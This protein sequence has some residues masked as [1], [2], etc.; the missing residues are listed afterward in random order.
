MN[1]NVVKLI[2][3]GVAGAFVGFFLLGVLRA[4]GLGI[5][6]DLLM[7]ACFGVVIF[8]VVKNL[9]TNR[10]VAKADP[11]VRQ[12][13]VDFMAPAL[14]AAALYIIREGFVGMA[15]GMDV[16]IDGRVMTQLKSP[17]FTRMDMAAGPHKMRVLFTASKTPAE[18][19]L[20]LAPGEIA[21]VRL[22]ISSGM[23][24]SQVLAERID[25][26]TIRTKVA[27]IQMA[28]LAPA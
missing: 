18:L 10:K 20:N 9:S 25:V 7:L 15:V 3:F 28:A 17:R 24:G 13:A 21:A 23:I 19:E 2:V 11:A 22:S 14:G 26:N 1:N 8:V 27:N 16:E 5:I 4:S 12:A 6:A